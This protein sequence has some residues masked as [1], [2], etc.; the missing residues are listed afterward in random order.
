VAI[1]NNRAGPAL[2][3]LSCV[4]AGLAALIAASIA[5]A[6][7]AQTVPIPKPAPKARDG[8]Q[9]I[10][11][12]RDLTVHGSVVDARTGKPVENFDAMPGAAHHEQQK[13]IDRDRIVPASGGLERLQQ[14]PVLLLPPFS[15]PWARAGGW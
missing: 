11:L 14:A 3:I 7:A 2:A 4:R 6:A 5:G 9:T 12:L 10:Q 13:W 8:V 1:P 15:S